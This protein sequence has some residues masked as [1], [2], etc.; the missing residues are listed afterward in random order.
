VIECQRATHPL[1]RIS[2]WAAILFAP[3]LVG[4]I[5]GMNFTHIAIAL[6]V[7]TSITL[8]LSS[9]GAAGS[10]SGPKNLGLVGRLGL[11]PRTDGL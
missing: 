8:Y 11:E 9:N 5:Y 6:M 10:E 1:Q 4:T 3:T 2:S 7:A